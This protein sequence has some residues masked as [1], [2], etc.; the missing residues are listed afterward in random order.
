MQPKQI[1]LVD[2]EPRLLA[3]L[4]RRLSSSFDIVTFERGQ[5]ALD[6]LAKPHNVAVIVADM[7]MPEM[8]GVELLKAVHKCDPNIRRLMLTGNADQE[9]AIAAINESKVYRFIRK[10]C[11][12]MALKE[13]LIEA[14][15]EHDFNNIDLTQIKSEDRQTTGLE[16]TQKTFLSIMSDELRTPLSQIITISKILSKKRKETDEETLDKFLNQISESGEMALEH[17]DRI[18]SY[19]HLQSADLQ[20]A[21]KTEIDIVGLLRE[22]ISNVQDDAK[23]KL[24][25]ITME[26]L[27]KSAAIQAAPQEV[28]TAVKEILRNA[29]KYSEIGGYVG[30][31]VRSEQDNIAVRISNSGAT[32]GFLERR[33][34]NSAFKHAQTGFDGESSGVGLGLSL[35]NL[36]A[37]RNDVVFNLQE[38]ENGGAVATF[39]FKRRQSSASEQTLPLAS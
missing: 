21:N 7:Q 23:R 10:P 30:V 29:V 25:K 8:N 27:R 22:E 20:E 36:V 4:R 31:L 19:T 12:A 17:I 3:A 35:V 37:S 11:D 9:T 5:A 38:K 24:V 28:K 1:M 16:H 32:N 14:L 6:Y 33:S 2:D 18:L 26:S 39:V 34:E 13:I 15:A